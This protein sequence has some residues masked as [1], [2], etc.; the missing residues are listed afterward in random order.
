MENIKGINLKE[1]VK[2]AKEELLTEQKQEVRAKIS[3]VYGG[4]NS[5]LGTVKK[6]RD[7]LQKAE[8]KHEKLMKQLKDLGNGNWDAMKEDKK[9][10]EKEE[11]EEKEDSK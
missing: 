2:N 1:E 11:K 8:A 9:E 4:I 5:A 10:R 7:Q 3:R 6:L